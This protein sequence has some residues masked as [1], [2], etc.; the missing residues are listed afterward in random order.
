M[1][2]RVSSPEPCTVGGQVSMEQPGKLRPGRQR[3]T[4]PHS[5]AFYSVKGSSLEW[6]VLTVWLCPLNLSG[7]AL[8]SYRNSEVTSMTV[9]KIWGEHLSGTGRP[10]RLTWLQ[11]NRHASEPTLST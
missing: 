4:W 1:P 6:E 11:L 9:V 8:F 3:Q 7:L 2:S 10:Y 5:R